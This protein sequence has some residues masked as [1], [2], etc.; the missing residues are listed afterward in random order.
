M[1]WPW[2]QPMRAQGGDLLGQVHPLGDG[3]HA[4]GR[5]RSA[6]ARR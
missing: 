5:R 1:P 6:A 2:V 4:R 3:L